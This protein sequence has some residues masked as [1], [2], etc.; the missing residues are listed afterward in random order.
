MLVDEFVQPLI[1][2]DETSPMILVRL[3]IRIIHLQ[4]VVSR[5]EIPV[6]SEKDVVLLR[7]S[8]AFHGSPLARRIHRGRASPRRNRISTAAHRTPESEPPLL[9]AF[10]VRAP[11]G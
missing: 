3:L 10:R 6:L 5:H 2:I 8:D 1:V 9:R 4:A 7:V 11:R